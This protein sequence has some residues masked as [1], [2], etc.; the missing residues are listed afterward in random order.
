MFEAQLRGESQDPTRREQMIAKAD[1]TRDRGDYV[2]AEYLYYQLLNSFDDVDGYLIQYAHC[3]KEQD[4]LP[5][6]E[7][8]YRDALHR[9]VDPVAVLE[10]LEFVCD[11][12]G[13][14]LGY[15]TPKAG[16]VTASEL[17]RRP[18]ST[19]IRVL[20]WLL[21]DDSNPP[22]ELRLSV[23]RE[24]ASVDEAAAMMATTS[25]FKHHN[26]KLLYLLDKA[27]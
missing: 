8:F 6:A 25:E 11:R 20:S 2:A 27:S 23:I 12:Q 13:Q 14:P 17:E 7:F 22:L 5:A 19:D 4:K 9:G 1:A 18:N 10:H 16:E 15:V 21:R 24:A 26:R 3:L